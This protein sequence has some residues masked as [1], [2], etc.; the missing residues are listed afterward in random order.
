M[1]YFMFISPPHLA[2]CWVI[3]FLPAY[4]LVSTKFCGINFHAFVGR[5]FHGSIFLCGVMF[6]DTS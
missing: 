3:S 4:Y 5:K 2:V 6:M 1:F